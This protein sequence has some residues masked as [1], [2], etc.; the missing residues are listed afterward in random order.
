MPRRR[1]TG[2]GWRGPSG[3]VAP[4]PVTLPSRAPS[5]R[6]PRL[7]ALA[8]SPPRPGRSPRRRHRP[9]R[10]D[11]RPRRGGAGGGP[12]G[13]RPRRVALAPTA[14]PSDWP[15]A[16]A[17]PWFKP[18]AGP[19]GR[20]PARPRWPLGP[21]PSAAPPPPAPRSP[22]AALAR[23]RPVT[24]AGRSGGAGRYPPSGSPAQAG[25]LSGC[26][27]RN[28]T[29]KGER[30]LKKNDHFLVGKCQKEYKTL[31]P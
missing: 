15:D 28:E 19:S 23:L 22:R 27:V 12:G 4:S 1:A 8:R 29:V 20:V 26:P 7:P 17:G 18:R 2:G 11:P 25:V 31:D 13:P 10:S 21:A 3:G 9:R 6:R 30:T 5:R 24:G 16:E 14:P